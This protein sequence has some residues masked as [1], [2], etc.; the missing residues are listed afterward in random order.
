MSRRAES[1]AIWLCSV[2]NARVAEV[3]SE[4]PVITESQRS[5]SCRRQVCGPKGPG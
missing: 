1:K 2:S 3:S 4:K 5:A